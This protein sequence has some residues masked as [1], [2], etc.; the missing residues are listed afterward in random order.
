MPRWLALCS[1][2]LWSSIWWL[3]IPCWTPSTNWKL[4]RE[5]KNYEEHWYFCQTLAVLSPLRSAYTQWVETKNSRA[6]FVQCP[7]APIQVQRDGSLEETHPLMICKYQGEGHTGWKISWLTWTR[8]VNL[9][10]KLY[11]MSNSP[12]SLCRGKI[13]PIGLQIW[14]RR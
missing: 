4:F 14:P 6:N 1:I 7:S 12:N 2:R 9:K 11:D 5:H 10:S 13:L 8:Y 3:D